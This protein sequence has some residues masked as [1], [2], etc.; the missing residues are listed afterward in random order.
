MAG[1][2]DARRTEQEAC[3]PSEAPTVAA[4]K[5]ANDMTRKDRDVQDRCCREATQLVNEFK[6]AGAVALVQADVFRLVVRSLNMFPDDRLVQ[7]AAL[8]AIRNL[9]RLGG[10]EAGRAAWDAEMT[11][12]VVVALRRAPKAIY[13]QRDGCEALAMFF[14]AGGAEA[15]RVGVRAAAT[16]SLV[17][18]LRDN[19]DEP[20]VQDA[21]CGALAR[22]LGTCDLFTV[23]SASDEGVAQVLASTIH[24][25]SGAQAV[26]VPGFATLRVLAAF[27][28]AEAVKASGAEKLARQMRGLSLHSRAVR[29]EARLLLREL[30]EEGCESDSDGSVGG[31][32][33]GLGSIMGSFGRAKLPG[34]TPGSFGEPS[35][36]GRSAPGSAPGSF[37]KPDVRP[38]SVSD[39]GPGSFGVLDGV[40][41]KR[42]ASQ[43]CAVPELDDMAGELRNPGLIGGGLARVTEALNEDM[44]SLFQTTANTGSEGGEANSRSVSSKTLRDSSLPSLPSMKRDE[45]AIAEEAKKCK[46]EIQGETVDPRTGTSFYTIN[47]SRGQLE[48]SVSRRY[49]EFAQ[50]S[51][52]LQGDAVRLMPPKSIIRRRCSESFRNR[53]EQGLRDFLAY[54]MLSDPRLVAPALR[55][56]LSVPPEPAPTLVSVKSKTSDATV[57]K[58]LAAVR[59]GRAPDPSPQTE[60]TSSVDEGLAELIEFEDAPHAAS[61]EEVSEIP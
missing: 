23:R 47:L 42:S 34:S 35:A 12:A 31:S 25:R 56:F 9:L 20:V 3:P 30:G 50:L 7:G 16:S 44:R 13:I 41:R 18:S 60:L 15:S 27:G 59:A 29:K 40:P 14:A 5:I 26:A 38:R 46:A 36:G 55:D 43:D 37:G 1:A 4:R 28:E 8:F 53:R 24:E 57:A 11:R 10:P 39:S 2:A 6:E 54:A 19:A 61:A 21:A 58:N 45:A 33:A 17:Q 49:R 51:L 32:F 52:M 22:M 48:W